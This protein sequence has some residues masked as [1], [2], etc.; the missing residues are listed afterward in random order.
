MQQIPSYQLVLDVPSCRN[1]LHQNN[2]AQSLGF[3]HHRLL[4][5]GFHKQQLEPKCLDFHLVL[6]SDLKLKKFSAKEFFHKTLSIRSSAETWAKPSLQSM[7]ELDEI[8][9][10]QG[11]AS[12][13][14]F[15]GAACIWPQYKNT[16][17]NRR[18]HWYRRARPKFW[19]ALSAFCKFP[20]ACS[21]HALKTGGNSAPYIY[22]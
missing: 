5:L 7:A 6:L 14:I 12:S 11:A 16:R 9:C 19:G 18:I 10:V 4:L 3:C 20:R 21:C 13:L 15:R 1:R 8:S 2:F 17:L 22:T